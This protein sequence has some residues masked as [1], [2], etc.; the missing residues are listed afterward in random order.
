[1]ETNQTIPV[2]INYR[3]FAIIVNKKHL[4]KYQ[5]FLAKI[6]RCLQYKKRRV[7]YNAKMLLIASGKFINDYLKGKVRCFIFIVSD[8]ILAK[9]IMPSKA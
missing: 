5:K 6:F 1:M 8:K 3:S 9:T 4:P 7:L 2:L